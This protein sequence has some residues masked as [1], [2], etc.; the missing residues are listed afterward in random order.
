[1]DSSTW[2]L[3]TRRSSVDTAPLMAPTVPTFMNT[4]VWMTPWTVFTWAL[5]GPAVSGYDLIFHTSHCS[6]LA[7]FFLMVSTYHR[8]PVTQMEEYPP[9]MMPAIRGRANSRILVTP[10]I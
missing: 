2:V 8:A 4:G 3:I 6:A 10:K 5:F 1:M 7:G 9:M